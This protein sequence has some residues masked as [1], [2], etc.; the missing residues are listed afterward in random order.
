VSKQNDIIEALRDRLSLIR[1]ANGYAT[2]I[3]RMVFRGRRNI[4]EDML[5]C[6]TIIEAEDEIERQKPRSGLDHTFP[7]AFESLPVTIE[8]HGP[9]DA[10]HP[11]IAA[12]DMVRDI[13]RAIFS[14]DLLFGGLAIAT[15][16]IGRTV[17]DREPGTSIAVGQVMIKIDCVED[18]ADP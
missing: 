17:G 2:D 9:C 11:S 6:C 8:A 10:D 4:S 7:L 5:P 15:Q 12:H 14:G 1:I 18:L 3:G 13:K 16:Y